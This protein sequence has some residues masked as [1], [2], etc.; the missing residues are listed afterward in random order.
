M[1]TQTNK[2]LRGRRNLFFE[3]RYLAFLGKELER[4][5]KLKPFHQL[6][7]DFKDYYKEVEPNANRK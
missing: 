1:K 3:K 6:K 2:T 4:N 7:F 5:K